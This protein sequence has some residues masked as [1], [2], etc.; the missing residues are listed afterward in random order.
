MPNEKD[1]KSGLEKVHKNLDVIGEYLRM[2]ADMRILDSVKK[3][4]GKE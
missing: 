1:L 2:P 3:K 4:E